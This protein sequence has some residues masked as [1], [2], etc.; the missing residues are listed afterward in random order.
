[1]WPSFIMRKLTFLY[2]PFYFAFQKGNYYIIGPVC[3]AYLLHSASF[4]WK[5][6]YAG[7]QFIICTPR[8]CYCKLGSILQCAG[9]NLSTSRKVGTLLVSLTQTMMV[10]VTEAPDVGVFLW[11]LPGW[12]VNRIFIDPIIKTMRLVPFDA[13]HTGFVMAFVSF[14]C[15]RISLMVLSRILWVKGGTA[16]LYSSVG[17]LN[18]CQWRW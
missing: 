13:R 9:S 8:E 1:M 14:C 16:F 10:H 5:L 7:I 4:F 3:L 17:W 18:A 15:G 11:I 2:S 6:I 12:I